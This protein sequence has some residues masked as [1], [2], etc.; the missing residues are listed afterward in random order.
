MPLICLE[1]IWMC[2]STTSQGSKRQKLV[3]L[4]WWKE[5]KVKQIASSN[6]WWLILRW[7][8]I[9][10]RNFVIFYSSLIHNMADLPLFVKVTCQAKFS[11]GKLYFQCNWPLWS[12]RNVSVKQLHF[13]NK[14]NCNAKIFTILFWSF[15]SMNWTMMSVLD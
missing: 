2:V 6:V 1:K 11:F 8:A 12:G 15:I 3:E 5:G 14:H 13:S 10:W 7:S 4:P 9:L